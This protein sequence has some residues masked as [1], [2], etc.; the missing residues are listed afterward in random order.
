[1]LPLPKAGPRKTT[2]RGRKRGSTRIITDTEV[3][4]DIAE[5]TLTKTQCKRYRPKAKKIETSSSDSDSDINMQ[6]LSDNNNSEISDDKI[7]AAEGD[8]VIVKVSTKP[9]FVHC[10]ARI[11]NINESGYE[12]VFLR[13]VIRQN[14]ERGFT[15]EISSNDEASWAKS[16]VIRKLPFP[17]IKKDLYQFSDD[18][19]VNTFQIYSNKKGTAYYVKVT[20]Y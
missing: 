20:S 17:T 16:D 8:F 3:R 14:D 9:H 4:N 7:E 6:L 13:R 2:N 11:D 1:M 15:F 18:Y 5:A 10:V 12:R 19:F